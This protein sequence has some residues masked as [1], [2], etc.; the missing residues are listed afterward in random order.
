VGRLVLER[1]VGEYVQSSPDTCLTVVG[2]DSAGAVCRRHPGPGRAL[3]RDLAR[4]RP[5]KVAAAT[6]PPPG[7]A[8]RVVFLRPRVPPDPSDRYS[9]INDGWKN[10][11]A[12]KL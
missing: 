9:R 11:A 12:R 5:Q 10:A 1:S 2:F 3:R 7:V 4:T 6:P 8:P